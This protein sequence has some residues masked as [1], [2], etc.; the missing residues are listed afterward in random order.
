MFSYFIC[1][2]SAI[3]V[4]SKNKILAVNDYFFLKTIGH[5]SFGEV[6][7]ATKDLIED[8]YREDHQRFITNLFF[9]LILI[10]N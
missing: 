6:K 1:F 2:F 7:L 3:E 5:G 8:D 9:S 10:T 4:T